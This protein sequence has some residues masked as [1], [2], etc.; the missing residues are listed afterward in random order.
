MAYSLVLFGD[1][2]LPAVMVTDDLSTGDVDST[3]LDSAGGVWDWYGSER[4]LP[5]KAQIVQKGQYAGT[6][7]RIGTEDGDWFMF[8][9]DTWS[10]GS[11]VQMLQAQV[12]RLKAAL[13]KR[14]KLWRRRDADGVLTWQ[15]ARLL[16]VK[17]EQDIKERVAAVAT[18]TAAFEVAGS[19]WMASDP[20]TIT[21][22]AVDGVQKPVLA[23]CTGDF[24]ASDAVLTVLSSS[25][26]ITLVEVTGHGIEWSWA[27]SLLIWQ[28]LVVDAGALTVR[29]NDADAY[30]GFALGVGHTVAGWLTLL[31]GLNPLWIRVTGGSASLSLVWNERGA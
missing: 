6:E 3:L 19:G 5:R 27:G 16:Q 8:Q 26:T 13:G 14:E 25:G 22:I 10:A 18:I 2:E 28:S 24:P 12:D 4:R 20:T 11:A 1:V 15:W 29:K 17:H 9:W 31:P 30:S 7:T 21:T 23:E